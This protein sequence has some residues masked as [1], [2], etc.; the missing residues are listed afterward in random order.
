MKAAPFEKYFTVCEACG[1]LGLR[2]KASGVRSESCP[3]CRGGGLRLV[4]PED[5]LFLGLPLFIDFSARAQA[6]RLK[7]LLIS[8]ITALLL[9]IPY[10]I[11][12]YALSFWQSLK[13]LL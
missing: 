8:I 12:V 2:A 1:G 6:R 9:I 4:L 10:L 11:F 5:D 7:A 13:S 3:V